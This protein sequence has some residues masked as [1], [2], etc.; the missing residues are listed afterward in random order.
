MDK[1]E[2]DACGYIYDPQ[3]GAP[4]D[5]IEPGDTVTYRLQYTLT[6]SDFEDL[7]LNDYLPLPVFDVGD[8]DDDGTPGPAWVFDDV[9]S[10]A[11]PASGHAK[12]GPA[13]T[14]LDRFEG[15]ED[16]AYI[17]TVAELVAN[18]QDPDGES[19]VLSCIG[20]SVL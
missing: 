18:D 9:I 16:T 7:F 5:G 11:A 3:A 1:Y 14:F 4:D 19:S 17:V 6:T 13:D 15:T 10:A 8:P 12:F 2:C 20:H